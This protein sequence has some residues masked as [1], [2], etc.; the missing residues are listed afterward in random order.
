VWS[1]EIVRVL[2]QGV[3][4]DAFEEEGGRDEFVFVYGDRKSELV[5]M[6][7]IGVYVLKECLYSFLRGGTG[8]NLKG[9]GRLAFDEG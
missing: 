7:V 4:D 8:R 6:R 2:G 3:V 5:D 9:D 1:F